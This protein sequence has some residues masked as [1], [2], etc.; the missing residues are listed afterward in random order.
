MGWRERATG[1]HGGEENGIWGAWGGM[2]GAGFCSK[3]PLLSTIFLHTLDRKHR[4][5][6]FYFYPPTPI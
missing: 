1:V 5:H 2:W 4:T 6:H 3:S